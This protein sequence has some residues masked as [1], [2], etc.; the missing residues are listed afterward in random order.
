M[1]SHDPRMYGRWSASRFA[2]A[3][4][5]QT[6]A[7]KDPQCTFSRWSNNL[8]RFHQQNS[9]SE[10]M[11]RSGARSSVVLRN[12]KNKSNHK[13]VW[14]LLHVHF[15]AESICLKQTQPPHAIF[16]FTDRQFNCTDA[17]EKLIWKASA[18]KSFYPSPFL[19]R[20]FPQIAAASIST[21]W[22]SEKNESWERPSTEP[23]KYVFLKTQKT[24]VWP[25]KHAPTWESW[26]C[27]KRT[28]LVH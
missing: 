10:L 6:F 7:R 2:D 13:N 1:L 8:G 16:A 17:D 20:R 23:K 18:S 22:Y 26:I 11:Q 4:L 15:L 14:N 25:R 24:R 9:T 27:A 19:L 5:P 28:D 21:A 3:W 12:S